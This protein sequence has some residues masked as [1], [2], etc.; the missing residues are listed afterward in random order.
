MTDLK[1][2]ARTGSVVLS[3]LER[4]GSDYSS[5]TDLCVFFS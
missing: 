2:K 5:Y 1:A 4:I 3:G